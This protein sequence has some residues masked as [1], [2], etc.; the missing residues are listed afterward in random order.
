M[1]GG[2][3]VEHGQAVDVLVGGGKRRAD[4]GDE[5]MK[6]EAAGRAACA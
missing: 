5:T 1:L 6:K 4:D 3:V 2:R